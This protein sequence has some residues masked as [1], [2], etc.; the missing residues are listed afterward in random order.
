MCKPNEIEDQ[1]PSTILMD[2]EY[3][4]QT[5]NQIQKKDPEL[6]SAYNKLI[7]DADEAL[8]KD[9]FSVSDK[10]IIA[11]SGNKNDY[12]SYS[13]YW[14]PDPTQP[15]GMPYLRRDGETNPESQNPSKSDRPR[16]GSIGKTTETLGLAYYFTGD[17]KYAT[18]AAELIR[19]WFLDSKTKM[20][21][22]LNHSQCRPGHNLGSRTGV[23]DGR[24]L[25]G[26][27]EASLLIENSAALNEEELKGLRNWA[28]E[29]FEWLTTNEMALKESESKN[30]HGSYYDVQALYFALYSDNK[31]MALKIANEFLDKRIVSQISID[32]TMPHELARTRPLFYTVYN[33]HAL[34]LVAHLAENL[35]INVWETNNEYS[36]LKLAIE[37]LLPYAD[38]NKK[39]P[40]PTISDFDRTP[41]FAILQ[42]ANQKYPEENYFDKALNFPFEECEKERC[43]LAFPL[44]R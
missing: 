32:G 18:K 23:L 15:N 26:A 3:L 36:R 7:K 1:V 16:I 12:A 29:F 4:I 2:S 13:R 33:L 34:L 28:K 37:F 44:I 11:P 40:K 5:K 25:I 24:L 39:W 41:M 22:N 21:P 30:N 42:M 14:W 6:M 9:P 31:E 35:E 10:E 27:L 38:P 17:E 20:N 8:S 43:N 19:V